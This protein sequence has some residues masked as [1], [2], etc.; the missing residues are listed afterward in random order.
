MTKIMFCDFCIKADMDSDGNVQGQPARDY[1]WL[2]ELDESK[3]LDI[4][5]RYTTNV[6]K[7]NEFATAIAEVH[8]CEIRKHFESCNFVSVIVDGSL[9]SSFTENEIVYMQ[10]CRAGM[11]HTNFIYCSQVEHG[12]AG[13]I[14]EA[15]QKAVK[16]VVPWD[17]FKSKLVALG[18]DGASVMLGKNNGVIALL[19][20][21]Q[22][23][24]IA[25]HCSGHRLELAYKDMI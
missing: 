11:I 15:I 1:L 22:P 18:S 23:S 6:N 2:N 25:V 13:Q 7:C 19:Q 10:T 5:K 9:D 24:I 14:V 20:T 4:G 3:G 16:T 8:R 21:M 17:D 12:N